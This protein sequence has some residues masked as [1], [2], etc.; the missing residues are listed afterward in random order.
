MELTAHPEVQ[1]SIQAEV[2]TVLQGQLPTAASIEHLVY[3]RGVLNETLRLHSPA[4]AL[5]RTAAR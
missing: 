3:T 5:A 2:D 4:P 1:R